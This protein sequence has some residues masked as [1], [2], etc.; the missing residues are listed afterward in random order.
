MPMVLWTF[1]K[2]YMETG[3]KCQIHGWVSNS[4][5]DLVSAYAENLSIVTPNPPMKSYW[6]HFIRTKGIGPQN[7]TC[8]CPSKW[9]RL[10]K[11]IMTSYC[12]FGPYCS[13]TAQIWFAKRISNPSLDF[14][15]DRKL[16]LGGVLCIYAKTCIY[17]YI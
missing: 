9:T 6:T 11:Y 7:P 13:H 10:E 16:N 4:D 12:V 3:Q 8:L 2:W 5:T 1:S 15:K 14:L 17:T